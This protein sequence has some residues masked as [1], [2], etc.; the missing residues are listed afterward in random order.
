MKRIFTIVMLLLTVLFTVS[1]QENL[2]EKK[3]QIFRF[4]LNQVLEK[5][6]YEKLK[7]FD[8]KKTDIIVLK[9]DSF[10]E[11]N[12]T[13]IKNYKKYILQ[14]N[15]NNPDIILNLQ[16]YK[17]LD[18]NDINNQLSEIIQENIPLYRLI[19]LNPLEEIK[20]YQNIYFSRYKDIKEFPLYKLKNN[21]TSSLIKT[22][23]IDKN[24]WEI[25]ENSYDFISKYIYDLEKG[26]IVK[27]E[28][29][30]RK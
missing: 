6:D 15:K 13:E 14:K 24:K 8:L 25:I 4:S 20:I 30:E 11:N 7:Y 2:F 18:V 19:Y 9:V 27:F 23:K 26:T 28:L 29:F 3:L 5:Y 17:K 22:N 12:K 16:K 21:I 10:I 1:S